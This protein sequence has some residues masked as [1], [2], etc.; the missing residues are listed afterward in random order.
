MVET[1]L[2][3]VAAGAMALGVALILL[4]ALRG[5]VEAV[6]PAATLDARVYRD[7]LREVERDRARGTIEAEE[8]GR[9]RTEVARRLLEA[10]RA[11]TASDPAPPQGP[12]TVVR[13]MS[14]GGVALLLAGAFAVYAVLGQPDMPDDPIAAR[15]AAAESLRSALPTQA[16]MEAAQPADAQR[17]VDP[18]FTTL[19]AELRTKLATRPDDLTGY[20]LLARNEANLGN[21]GAAWKAQAHVIGILGDTATDG[22]RMLEATLMVQAAG[23]RVSPE[24]WA[25]LSSVVRRDPA[26]DSAL[27]FLG[28]GN[29]QV[30]RYDLAFDDW[31]QLMETAP[32]QSPWRAEA[33]GRIGDLAALA[34]VEYDPPASAAPAL[35]GPDAGAVSDAAK[36]APEDRTKMIRGMVEQL[37]E[38]L[39]TSGGTSEEWARLIQA[40]GVLGETDRA[41]AIW[42]EARRTFAANPGDLATVTAAATAAGVAK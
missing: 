28:I 24:A 30:G 23:G 34:G 3:W 35:P 2:F 10:D 40:L 22:D 13:A 18:A 7:Q 42:A 9:L 11:A 5:P 32:A 4:R 20:R 29:L 21:F 1:G 27:F 33:A 15:I 14:V 31:R 39:A 25:R 16:A 26:N 17:P 19:M 38:R 37:G 36:M 6:V 8:A 12:G 41:T